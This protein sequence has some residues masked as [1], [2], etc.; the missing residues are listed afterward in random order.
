MSFNT[1]FEKMNFYSFCRMKSITHYVAFALIAFL[2]GSTAKDA[3]PIVFEDGFANLPVGMFSS[4]VGAKTEYH[5]LSDAAPKGQW[6]VSCFHWGEG[7]GKAW[8]V[9]KT[10]NGQQA[11]RQN[12]VNDKMTHTHP[13]LAAGNQVWSDYKLSAVLTALENSAGRRMGV[14]V[15]Y[16]TNRRYYFVGFESGKIKILKIEHETSFRKANEKELG[17][18]PFH[19][20]EN[21]DIALEVALEGASIQVKV[22]HQLVLQVNDTSY[23]RG[24]IA[25]LADQPT[26]F[27]SIQ[28]RMR[29]HTWKK[30]QKEAKKIQTQEAELQAQHPQPKVWKKLSISGFGVGRNLRFG[31][32]N[33]DGK[34]DILIGQVHQ[35]AA[36]SDAYAELSC[37]TAIDLEGKVLWQVG[38]PDPSKNHL[39]NDVAFQIH[40]WDGDGKNEVVY[41]MNFEIIVADGATGKTKFKASTP[42][43]KPPADRFERVLGDC[44]SFADF[45]GIGRKS[46]LIIKDRYTHFWVYDHQLKEIWSGDCNTGHFPF[47]YDTDRDGKDE[48]FI[49]YSLYDHDGKQLWSNDA[50]LKDHADAVIVI[51]QSSPN[52]QPLVYYAASDDGYAITNL[53]GKILHHQNLGHCQNITIADFRPDHP[54]IETVMINFWGN[55]GVTFIIDDRGKILQEFEILNMGSLCLPVNWSGKKG[56]FFLS[57]PHPVHGGMYDGWGRKV[58]VFP[59]DGHPDM[60]NAVLDLTGDIRDE[61]VVWNPEEI[62]I[63]TQAGPS[64]PNQNLPKVVRS[65]LFGES[66]YRAVYSLPDNEK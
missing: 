2:L 12:F 13:M 66:N 53:E 15:R 20:K 44:I 42:I 16:Q 5:Y 36:P 43:A 9:V 63:Y 32:L 55:Q 54:G 56:E 23:A 22:N 31:D 50:T 49:G 64:I 46:D 38:K 14:G 34:K 24:K 10:D 7:W 28:V 47:A 41:T 35:H 45:K 39:T 11:M 37:L 25:I 21:Q 33:G 27:K 61:I 26:L 59:K 17:S 62:W 60:C 8:E 52:N 57:N 3:A 4:N 6:A 19:F 29:N 1:N 65:P 18:A 30:V 40:D 48:L 58:V 51:P